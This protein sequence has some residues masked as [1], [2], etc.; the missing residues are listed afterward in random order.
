MN[1]VTK[2][3]IDEDLEKFREDS[4]ER[5]KFYPVDNAF[6]HTAFIWG[7]YGLYVLAKKRN[8]N[9]SA[10]TVHP[11]FDP[12]WLLRK[13]HFERIEN[14]SRKKLSALLW[15]IAIKYS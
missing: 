3:N 1:S 12:L 9:A 15:K 14:I 5:D 2:T 6:S 4:E 10:A 11:E 13:N 7:L 8:P